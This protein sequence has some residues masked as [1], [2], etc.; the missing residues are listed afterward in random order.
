MSNIK[1]NSFYSLLGFAL[2]TIVVLLGYPIL[3]RS[4]GEA[5][6]GLYVLATSLSGTLAF[7]DLGI[8]AATLKFVAES[9]ARGDRE[10]FSKIVQTSFIFYGSVG[11]S[12][13][14]ILWYSSP[15][16]VKLFSVEPGLTM[17]GTWAF[18]ISAIQF[19]IFFLNTVFLS[20]FKGVQRFD[21]SSLS[22]TLLSVLTY[23]GGIL[24]A[25]YT[26]LG[27]VGITGASLVANLMSLALSGYLA[28]QIFREHGIS[29][30]NS[31]PTFEVFRNMFSFSSILT[32]NSLANFMLYQIQRYLIG[33]LLGPAAVSAYQVAMTIPSKAHSV[34]NAVT[35]TLFPLASATKNLQNLRATYLKMLIASL[36]IAALALL[37]LAVCS[38]LLLLLWM[39]TPAGSETGRLIPILAAA[40]FFIALSPAPY[41]IA[42]GAGKPWYNTAA[43]LLNGLTNLLFIA[44][45]SIDGITIID[46]AWA[47]AVSNIL[48]AIIYQAWIE[49]AI[50]RRQKNEP[51][52]I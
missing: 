4:L 42:N 50:W 17:E 6:F 15:F 25:M 51:V 13:A 20:I 21:L 27:L 35:E 1:K 40:Y 22:L 30:K 8:S 32:L 48:N 34:V 28:K 19:S 23:G 12:G 39:G 33:I 14:I 18:R 3:I 16:L 5:A 31:R 47:F 45:F 10:R 44:I 37:P 38:D 49:L 46:F 9:T 7:L 43:F 52:G 26:S 36:C 29:F 11:L 41:H 24:I 2:P